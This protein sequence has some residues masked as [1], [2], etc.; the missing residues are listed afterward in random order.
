MLFHTHR[1]HASGLSV[2][3]EGIEAEKVDETLAP[4]TGNRKQSLSFTLR[5][6]AAVGLAEQG[7]QAALS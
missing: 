6:R 4:V 1:L 2:L 7:R 3:L 5:Y